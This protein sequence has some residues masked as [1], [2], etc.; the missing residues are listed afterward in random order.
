MSNKDIENFTVVKYWTRKRL[1]L[2]FR[3]YILLDYLVYLNEQ[4]KK[5]FTYKMAMDRFDYSKN[6]VKKCLFTII[7]KRFILPR[8]KKEEL[9]EV[10]EEIANHMKDKRKIFIIIFHDKKKEHK[11]IDMQFA[12]LSLVYSLSKKTK[13]KTAFMGKEGYRKNLSIETDENYYKTVRILMHQEL[14]I[15]KGISSFQLNNDLYKWFQSK[16]MIYK[17]ISNNS[18]INRSNSTE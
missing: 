5:R 11:L 7:S 8:E 6:T 2:S 9:F 15:K 17:E 14:L 12:F 10:N 13:N 3:E 1:G 16:E 4:K 18:L